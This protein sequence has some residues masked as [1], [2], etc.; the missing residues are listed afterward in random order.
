MAHR[1]FI[2]CDHKRVMTYTP[3]DSS[4]YFKGISMMLYPRP[5]TI[6]DGTD[7]RKA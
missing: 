6:L 5:C 2:D 3:G 7:R 4:L 1:V